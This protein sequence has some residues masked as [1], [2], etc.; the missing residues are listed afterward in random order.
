M[1]PL[2]TASEQGVEFL[3]VEA[4]AGGFVL[5]KLRTQLL[6][7]RVVPFH[8]EDRRV[9]TTLDGL[10]VKGNVEHVRLELVLEHGREPVE[11]GGEVADGHELQGQFM[12]PGHEHLV[13]P[14]HLHQVIELAGELSV[15]RAQPVH[16]AFDQ[17][18]RLAAFV[19]QHELVEEFGA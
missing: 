13:L 14:G 4:A 7:F 3:A 12:E 6:Q 2:G 1:N 8:L 16:L 17:G 10:A 18:D 5:L 19:R 11:E 9:V 15:A